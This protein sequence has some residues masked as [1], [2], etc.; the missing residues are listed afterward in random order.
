MRCFAEGVLLLH[1]GV[2]DPGEQEPLAAHDPPVLVRHPVVGI[3]GPHPERREA[4]DRDAVDEAAGQRAAAPRGRTHQFEEAVEIGLGHRPLVAGPVLVFGVVGQD[5]LVAGELDDV[6]VRHVVAEGPGEALD[7]HVGGGLGLRELALVELDD[8]AIVAGILDRHADGGAADL[9]AVHPP[10]PA[11]IR[12]AAGPRPAPDLLRGDAVGPVDEPGRVGHLAQAV[13]V[14]GRPVP[15][16]GERIDRRGGQAGAEVVLDQA[17]LGEARRFDRPAVVHQGHR[18]PV[19]EAELPDPVRSAA[20]A[21]GERQGQEDPAPGHTPPRMM[22]KLHSPV[23]EP[24]TTARASLDSS[25]AIRNVA[26]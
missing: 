26:P 19:D 3:A 6:V 18:G 11:G 8:E 17:G 13:D 14:A 23:S 21:A 12:L 20:A 16:D 9:D 25:P 7:D 22:V 1:V 24:A 4:A 15:P 2:V 10:G 5:Q